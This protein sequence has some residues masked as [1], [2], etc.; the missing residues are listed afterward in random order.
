MLFENLG[1]Y[2]IER[3][4]GRGGMGAVYEGIHQT[5][6]L[7]HA[8]KT[9]APALCD[10]SGFRQRFEIEILSMQILDHPNIVRVIP[11][12]GT[13]D[14]PLFLMEQGGNLFYA[15]E[16]VDGLNLHQW[17]KERRQLPWKEVLDITIQ[18]CSALKH[19][20]AHG[21][22]HRDLKPANL[23][24]DKSGH[25]K[26]TD[27]GIARF[28]EAAHLT[29]P[30]G[31]IGT[32]DYMSP[33]QADGKPVDGLTDLYSLGAVMYAL[34]SG[35][36]PYAGRTLTEV[37]I[38]LKS[39][40]AK[41]IC[42]VVHDVPAEVGQIVDQL[43][44]KSPADRIPTLLSLEH[45]LKSTMYG[46]RRTE[47]SDEPSEVDNEHSDLKD[48]DS[49][50]DFNVDEEATFVT[51]DSDA[52]GNATPLEE[53]PTAST[54]SPFNS[55]A[56]GPSEKDSARRHDVQ[57]VSATIAENVNYTLV[58][59]H[60]GRSTGTR[61]G[62][63]TSRQK[64]RLLSA[65]SSVLLITC[66]LGVVY[67]VWHYAQGPTAD[68]L[69]APIR[70]VAESRDPNNYTSVRE[71]MKQFVKRH[72]QDDRFSIVSAM[73][74]DHDGYRRWKTL[75]RTAR[76]DGGLMALPE[77]QRAYVD[78]MR[79]RIADPSKA[80]SQLKQF[81]QRFEEDSNEDSEPLLDMAKA[82]VQV[83]TWNQEEM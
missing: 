81:I 44:A 57:S 29:M 58:D 36:P 6:G 56:A 13:E 15:M 72:Q 9:L 71:E 18:V 64:N 28:F 79:L 3:L 2:K 74:V 40:I 65:L 62:T 39:E 48:D 49:D 31:A 37:L 73:L 19:A 67:L 63:K 33:E 69:Y 53:R 80:I 50:V 59:I 11:Q 1:P 41:P 51:S 20:H 24:I 52:S 8:I 60:S 5:T 10:N 32:A 78:A 83:L 68:Q 17:L 76:T 14:K 34:L 38:R 82:T 77:I 54:P 45:R 75:E 30:G 27:F 42:H 25:I 46:L 7:R 47:Q 55:N 12:L 43:L 4:V 70:E 35:Q 16:F 26:L 22:I 61:L 21:V 23:L 66:L